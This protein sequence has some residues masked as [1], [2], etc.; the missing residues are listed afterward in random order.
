MTAPV[1]SMAGV[2][3]LNSHRRADTRGELRKVVTSAGL[4][5]VGAPAE[6]D[7]VVTT[8]NVRAGTVRGLHYQCEPH[9]QAK[10]LWVTEGALFDV[11]VDLRKDSPTYGRWMSVTLSALDDHSLHLPYGVAHGYQTL[12]DDTSI[13]YLISGTHSPEHARTLA[14][15]DSSLGISWPRPVTSISPSDL[16]GHPWPPTS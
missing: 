7:E 9:Q 12:E 16:C 4:R 6:F 8:T 14:W 3:L 13:S 15:D 10:T 1:P 11:V 2:H 5:R